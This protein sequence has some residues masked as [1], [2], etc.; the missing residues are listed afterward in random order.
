MRWED[1]SPVT[2][3]Q[4]RGILRRGGLLLGLPADATGTHSL[5]SGGATALYNATQGNTKVVQRMGRW[6]SDVFEGYV[7]E[8]RSLTRGMSARMLA[9]PWTIHTAAY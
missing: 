1:G 4:V 2:R 6:A 7:W 9:A 8:D 3:D 5:R